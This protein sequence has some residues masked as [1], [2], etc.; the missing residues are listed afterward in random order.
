MVVL[1]S[2]NVEELNSFMMLRLPTMSIVSGVLAFKC[3]R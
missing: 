3:S 1:N 2:D